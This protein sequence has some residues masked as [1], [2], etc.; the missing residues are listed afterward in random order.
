MNEP[1]FTPEQLKNFIEYARI[2]RSGR[3]NMF[4]PRAR[5]KTNMTLKEWIFCMENY[6]ALEKA[7]KE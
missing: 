1:T 2:Q 5:V 7:V 6:F 3:Y 4:D